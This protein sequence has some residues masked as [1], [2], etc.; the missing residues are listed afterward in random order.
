MTK[1]SLKRIN[2]AELAA[3]PEDTINF[4]DIPELDAAFWRDAKLVQADK[5][6][7]VTLRVKSSVLEAYKSLGKGYQTQMN[8]VL[9]TYAK[10]MRK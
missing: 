3:M 5:T 1:P 7:Q 6:Q 10:S 9:E 8:R 4:E 2:T